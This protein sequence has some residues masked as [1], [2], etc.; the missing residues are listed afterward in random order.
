VRSNPDIGWTARA[1]RAIV[2][3]G[4]SQ[5]A[6]VK[7]PY[8][9]CDVSNNNMSSADT[10]NVA[11]PIS[12]L[13]AGYDANWFSSQQDMYV[14]VYMGMPPN[15]APGQFTT[16]DLTSYIFGQVD[17]IEFDPANQLIMLSGRDLT[18]V[19]IDTKSTQ[20]YQNLTSSQIATELATAHGLTP[21]VTA[22]K[23][24]V[25]KYYDLDHVQL[26][27]E[28]T[29][30]DLLLYLAGVEDFIVYV[31]NQTLY[32]GPR[33]ADVVGSNP[34]SLYVI[35]WQKPFVTNA[36]SSA[37]PVANVQS[38]QFSRALTVSRGVQ[39]VIRSWNQKQAKGFT[40]SYPSGGKSIQVGK[41]TPF[42]GAQVY[43]RTFPNLTQDQAQKK[44][45]SL[46]A[47]IVAHEMKLK[48]ELPGD[49]ILDTTSVIQVT[50]TGTAY[51]QIYYPDSISRYMHWDGGFSMTVSA[52]NFASDSQATL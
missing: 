51:D 49:T 50:G 31:R 16:A 2:M 6:M 43:V 17:S 21:Q 46:Y 23:T 33:P 8:L 38:L 47:A 22:T 35:K 11:L 24:Q 5:G 7:M 48:A 37:S 30:W 18:R 19:F 42:G 32:F 1:P 45:Q 28:R 15:P 14:Q 34:Q 27:D 40:A 52:K 39:V 29:E 36:G 3:V 44:A 25:G 20:K 10:F 4:P 12:T 9:T 26:T 13:P 41:A